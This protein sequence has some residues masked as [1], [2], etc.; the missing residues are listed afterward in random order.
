[1]TKNCGK[2]LSKVT[3]ASLEAVGTNG[4]RPLNLV[5]LQNLKNFGQRKNVHH[6]THHVLIV[7]VV[8][9]EITTETVDVLFTAPVFIPKVGEVLQNPEKCQRLVINQ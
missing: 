4:D 3:S 9:A 1:M 7:V 2:Y 6:F 5:S 8:M